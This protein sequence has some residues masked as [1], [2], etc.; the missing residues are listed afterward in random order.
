MDWNRAEDSFLVMSVSI[1]LDHDAIKCFYPD[2]FFAFTLS[3]QFP[4]KPSNGSG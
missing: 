1:V 2:P 3:P 4:L